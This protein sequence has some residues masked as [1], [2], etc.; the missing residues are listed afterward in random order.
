MWGATITVLHI[1]SLWET[2]IRH[3]KELIDTDFVLLY[4]GCSH[5]SPVG[6]YFASYAS[7]LK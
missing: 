7:D 1:K 2:R 3:N 4:D 5:Y 6:T